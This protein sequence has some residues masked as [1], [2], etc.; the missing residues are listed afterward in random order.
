MVDVSKTKVGTCVQCG[1]QY[2]YDFWKTDSK[3]CSLECKYAAQSDQRTLKCEE[4]GKE[5]SCKASE[6]ERRKF[7][8]YE[9]SDTWNGRRRRKREDRECAHCKKT[10]SVRPSSDRKYCSRQCYLDHRRDASMI[11]HVC[12]QCGKKFLA[13]RCEKNRKYCSHECNGAALSIQNRETRECPVCGVEFEVVLSS[14]QTFCSMQCSN[15]ARM[16]L[17]KKEMFSVR[18]NTSRYKSVAE[19]KIGRKLRAFET[20]HHIDMDETNDAAD[21]LCV[22]KNNSEHHIVHGTL[23]R[24][25][26]ELMDIGVLSFDGEKYTVAN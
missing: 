16:G 20:V 2:E 11:E 15:R 21:N 17:P 13:Q 8:S 25:V 7:C 4:C 26:K 19:E 14:R 10:F 9:C 6:A 3:Y 24:C 1:A 12:E 18:K 22:L 5:F 23:N